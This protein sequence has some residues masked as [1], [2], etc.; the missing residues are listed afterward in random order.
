MSPPVQT[1]WPLVAVLIAGGLIAAFQVGKAAIGV[2]LVRAGLGL[3]LATAAAVVGV[4]GTLGAVAGLMA[5]MAISRAG[6]RNAAVAGLVVIGLGSTLGAFAGS[7][8]MLLTSRALEGCGFLAVTIATPALLRSISAPAD[9]DIVFTLWAAYMPGG[10]ALMM[11]VAPALTGFG[12]QGLWL[13]NGGLALAYAGVV[14]ALAPNDGGAAAASG[15]LRTDTATVL[16]APGP[17]LLAVTFGLYTF[18]Y[19]ALTGLLPTLL[20]E[21][22]GLGLGEAGSIAAI[23]VVANML[24]NLAAGVLGRR[25]V[26]LWGVIAAAFAVLALASF[27]IFAAAA[28]AA[29]VAVLA[30]LSL[31]IAGL[32]P[33]SIFAA[34]QRLVPTAGLLAVAIGLVM[35]A[36]NLGQVFGPA[37]LG[38]VAGRLGWSAAPVLFVTVALAGLA[39]AWRLRG[40][41]RP[42]D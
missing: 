1:R 25:G 26:P 14:A 16:R 21:R 30:S 24:G 4:Y 11:L 10:T 15:N 27:G 32:I 35:Q 33:G 39:I 8:G 36:S 13:I 23:T 5:G 42:S 41:L 20:V 29:V 34:T 28:P 12:W 6:A 22:L 31:G 2:P 7:G 37:A 19:F 3:D 40:L 18:Q 17:V 38:F 9:R